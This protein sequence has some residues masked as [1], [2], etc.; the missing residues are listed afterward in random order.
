MGEKQRMEEVSLTTV[1]K[2]EHV[3]DAQSRYDKVN[4]ELK[5]WENEHP[6]YSVLHS[7]YQQLHQHLS[8]VNQVLKDAERRLKDARATAAEKAKGDI[9]EQ[10]MPPID[11]GWTANWLSEFRSSQ[12][13]SHKL[14]R[15]GQLM[16]FIESELPVK[17]AIHPLICR[18]WMSKMKTASPELMAKL[19][20]TSNSEPCVEF[21]FH[22]LN[23]FADA[24]VDPGVTKKSFT[25]FW[26]DMICHVLNYVLSGIGKSHR[27]PTNLSSSIGSYCPDYLF[28]VDSVCVLRGE[29]KDPGIET[30][31]CE[32]SEKLIWNH[33]DVPYLFAYAAVGFDVRLYAITRVQTSSGDHQVDAKELGSFDLRDVAGR[34]RLLL[35]LLNIARLF[36]SIARLCP[37]SSRDEYKLIVH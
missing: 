12:I 1:K 3:R 18:K 10:M 32:L 2:E 29:E 25:S 34:L 4:A 13:A 14:P 19:F 11:K 26:D 6:N 37:E 36:R 7:E 22:I 30:P 5:K 31:H 33:G 21:L 16:E 24:A 20:I 17:I 35:A 9:T 23:R 15:L 28:I 27:K 8:D